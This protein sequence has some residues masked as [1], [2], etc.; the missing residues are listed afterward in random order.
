MKGND[1]YDVKET[2]E[3]LHIIKK[4][5]NQT[6][7]DG[8]FQRW[9]G[10]ERGSGW[11]K[12]AAEQYMESVFAGKVFNKIMNA[13]VESCYRCAVD[14]RD[15][16]S[17][18]Y[19]KA[20]LDE[21]HK[22]VS[23]DGNNS[24]ST[25]N[26]YIN[27]EFAVYTDLDPT[28][29]GKGKK[30]KYFRDLSESEQED[31]LYT[32]KLTYYTF[33][34]IGIIEMC[35]LFRRENT[36]THLNKQEYRQAR[37]S[38]MAKFVRDTANE[39]QNRL[40]FENLMTM[41]AGD[42]DKRKH[43]EALAQLVQKIENNY[44]TETGAKQLDSFYEDTP[45]LSK[46]TTSLVAGVMKDVALIAKD[47]KLVKR[48]RMS[49]GLVQVLFDLVAYINSH[50]KEIKIDNHKQFMTWFL[51]TDQ[52]FRQISLKVLEE[53]QH[54]RSYIYWLRVYTQRTPLL[55][56][57]N[58]FKRAITRDLVALLEDGTM[59]SVRTSSDVFSTS[60]RL[61]IFYLQEGQLR[62]GEEVSILDL[63]TG[64]LEADHM[65]SVKDGGSTTIDNGELMTVYDNRQK[66]A[67]SN[68]PHFNHQKGQ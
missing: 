66:G 29:R 62:T 61:K 35:E 25:F 67:A 19:F 60:Q 15:K 28:T 34:K 5:Y 11:T 16:E 44:S 24:A 55:K 2:K 49:P 51:E 1:V 13:E 26:A 12:K 31:L 47:I 21:G 54:E 14:I 23:I 58:L 45:E 63:Y 6:K 50:K 3:S 20:L 8:S 18:T 9:G 38:P 32:E 41:S 46:T 33:R 43:E 53:D 39:P 57:L 40:I 36:S 42:L 10:M 52:A 4:K 64:K 30:K 37:W 65:I 68:Q 59:A 27:N 7:L 22:Y 17:E 56:S 48:H